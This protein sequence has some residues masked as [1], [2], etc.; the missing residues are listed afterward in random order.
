MNPVRSLLALLILLNTA[1]LAQEKFDL[2]IV[3]GRVMDPESGLDE[4]RELGI[5]DGK[6]AAIS[7]APLSGKDTID[8]DGL[9][10]TPD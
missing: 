5:L 2:V 4:I 8:A 6:I 1:G 9:I 3:N 7:E 10:V